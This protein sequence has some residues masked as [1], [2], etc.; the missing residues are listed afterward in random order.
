MRHQTPLLVALVELREGVLVALDRAVQEN[1][2][3]ERSNRT[4]DTRPYRFSDVVSQQELHS[5]ALYREFYAELGV[6]HQIA[7]SS[8]SRPR[9]L[10]T[11]LR[12]WDHTDLQ[13][14]LLVQRGLTTRE[15]VV[16][17]RVARGQSNKDIAAALG[18]SDRT[19][20]KHLQRCYRK[21]AA[22]NRSHAAAIAWDLAPPR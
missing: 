22:A 4:G 12:A 7:L 10:Q 19:I 11:E 14:E 15:A 8:R 3:I 18:V 13:F 21:L 20:G 16:L 2:L 9:A 17:G 6:E 1:P 5:L